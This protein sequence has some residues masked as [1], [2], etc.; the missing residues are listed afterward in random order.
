MEFIAT[1]LED[2]CI[3]YEALRCIH[4]GLLCVQHHP[5]DRPNMASVVVL[6]SNENALPL[7]KYP[8]YLI[9][10]ISTERESSSEKFTSYSI[11][12]VTISMLSDR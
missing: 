2:S 5:N 8:R 9:T 6:L 11:N 1:S 4:I 7:P 10:D 12:D 3:L